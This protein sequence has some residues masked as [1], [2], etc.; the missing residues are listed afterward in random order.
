MRKIRFL[1]ILDG[2]GILF[3]PTAAVQQLQQLQ[4]HAG[5]QHRRPPG[6]SRHHGPLPAVL[7]GLHGV[8]GSFWRPQRLHPPHGPHGV[9]RHQRVPAGQLRPYGVRRGGFYIYI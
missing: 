4:Q 5:G 2:R 8:V 6:C 3:V 7:H 1:G 9:G